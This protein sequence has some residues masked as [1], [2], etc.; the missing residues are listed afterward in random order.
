MSQNNFSRRHF[1]TSA[2]SSLGVLG[3]GTSAF[4]T[5]VESIMMKSLNLAQAAPDYSREWNYIH[6][7]LP[8]GPPR[9]YFDLAL[10][11]SGSGSD[12]KAG[13]F[14]NWLS[15]QGG[16]T[17]SIHTSLK[18][19]NGKR[20]YYI[21][22]IWGHNLNG[23]DFRKTLLPHTLFIRGI[24]ME[25][26][27]HPIS[28]A[29]QVAP[30]VNGLSL[31][32]ILADSSRKPMSSVTSGSSAGNAFRSRKGLASV[33]MPGGANPMTTLLRP[34]AP[35]PTAAHMH[36]GDWSRVVEQSMSQFEAYAK[37][38]RLP[39]TSQKEAYDNAISMINSNVMDLSTKTA[40]AIIK[41][42]GLILSATKIDEVKK[43][44]NF[45][46]KT[47]DT[48]EYR[49]TQTDGRASAADLRDAFVNNP[50]VALM[51]E[52]FAVTEVLI[53]NNI[54][55]TV[56]AG[57]GGISGLRVNGASFAQTND[58]H[59]IG[60]VA[61]TLFTTFYYR[62][63]IACLSELTATLKTSGKFNK[64]IIHIGAEFNRIPR[65]DGSGSDHGVIGSS[66][67]LISGAFTQ[68]DVI[69]NVK[70]DPQGSATYIG[71]W[72]HS[73]DYNLGG[74]DRPIQVNDV[75]Y[76][77]ALMMGLNPNGL[78]TNAR[79]LVNLSTMKV[80]KSE[81]KNV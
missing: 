17:T 10:T 39:A 32:G 66:A 1:L 2:A 73:A 15:L 50:T 56:T 21:P 65:I 67:T 6:F 36:A 58:Q 52:Q 53:N 76:T 71:T 4:N 70:V 64:T 31:S 59:N 14:G 24:D 16:K 61:S 68:F 81:A 9:W 79:S 20:D 42:R 80:L 51:A 57:F 8:G 35:F 29:R 75:A 25:I 45:V 77:A 38:N 62:A 47:E 12:F 46:M 54:T 55:P 44:F 11:P 3:V 41:Y 37:N 18:Y 48:R 19:N 69:G 60:R 7:S 72:G 28:N 33:P 34:F 49:I 22:P 13:G 5:M 74:M 63:I 43:V 27:N 40:E 30:I 26:N 78:V 23:V